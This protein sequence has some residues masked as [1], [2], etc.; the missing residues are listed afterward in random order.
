MTLKQLLSD[1]FSE[2]GAAEK[3][4]VLKNLIQSYSQKFI[5]IFLRKLI[6]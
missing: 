1:T 5:F 4:Q 3:L 6:K 2:H